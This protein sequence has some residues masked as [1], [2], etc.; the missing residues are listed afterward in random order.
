MK[1]HTQDGDPKRNNC[2]SYMLINCKFSHG[3]MNSL[4]QLSHL[5]EMLNFSKAKLQNS[6]SKLRNILSS[7]FLEINQ[8]LLSPRQIYDGKESESLPVRFYLIIVIKHYAQ[9]KVHSYL[10]SCFSALFNTSYLNKFFPKLLRFSI[11]F[12]Q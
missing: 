7:T 1:G 5:L 3:H 8:V 6:F 4:Q 11:R 12:V 2:R 10:Q 9:K